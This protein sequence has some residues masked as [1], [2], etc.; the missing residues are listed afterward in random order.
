MKSFLKSL[1]AARDVAGAT[2]ESAA[3]TTDAKSETASE[4]AP[5]A[6]IPGIWDAASAHTAGAAGF[7]VVLLSGTDTARSLLNSPNEGLAAP[8]EVG[9]V[10][11]HLKERPEGA[12]LVDAQSGFGNQLTAHFAVRDLVAYGADGVMINDQA[13][14]SRNEPGCARDA[15]LPELLARLRAARDVTEPAG[16]ALIA[17]LDGIGSYGP[18]ELARRADAIASE[19]LADFVAARVLTG[20]EAQLLAPLA[21]RMPLAVEARGMGVADVE[22]LRSLGFRLVLLP[23]ALTESALDATRERAGA[24]A[25]AASAPVAGGAAG[26]SPAGSAPAS[27]PASPAV[28]VAAASPTAPAS[29]AASAPHPA[30]GVSGRF[31]SDSAKASRM[32]AAFKQMC[33]SGDL[34]SMVVAPDALTA[35]IAESVGFKAI[36]SAGYATSAA[37][38]ARPDRGIA[39]FGLMADNAREIVNAVNIPVFVDGDTGYG[40]E[41]NIARMVRVY[42]NL[43][44][45]GLFIEDQVWPKRCGHMDGKAVVS[46]EEGI[47]RVAAAAA[48]R[49]HDDFL[50]M[51]R[52]DAY[53]TYGLDEAI[54]RTRAYHEAGADLC[55]IEAPQTREDM[56]RIPKLFT[57]AP[58]MANMIESGKTP[59][60]TDEE[61]HAAGYTIGVHPCGI[62]YTEAYAAHRLLDDMQRFGGD[63]KADL[64]QMIAFPKFNEFVGLS[65]INELEQRFAHI[66]ETDG[67]RL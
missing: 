52:T 35:R 10:L 56:E 42:E 27:A 8:S 65:E 12:V 18:D 61:I 64:D 22:R 53:A 20:D 7:P 5:F 19:S 45:A 26:V 44:A 47:R 37:R 21:A 58:L 59:L 54:E 38:L 13:F 41:E 63:I 30:R 51:S 36:F 62:V 60:M 14:P 39:D 66:D 32:R 46:K 25:A 11:R 2:P 28:S 67:N 16:V 55:F 23:D 1:S 49:R 50:I 4:A 9:W 3:D 48:A 40:D 31:P 34:V 24:L 6:V 33:F 17:R 57:D 15:G 29:P 43:G